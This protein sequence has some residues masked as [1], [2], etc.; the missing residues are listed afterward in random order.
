ML[1]S[2]DT[3]QFKVSTDKYYVAI[4]QAQVRGSLRSHAFLKLTADNLPI[5]LLD[6]G[7]KYA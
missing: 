5:F 7:L 4:S 6:R 3:C 1:C 2:I